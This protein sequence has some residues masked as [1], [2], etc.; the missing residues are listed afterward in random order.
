[1]LNMIEKFN[2]SWIWFLASLSCAIIFLIGYFF[3]FNMKSSDLAFQNNTS[4][5]FNEP[6]IELKALPVPAVKFFLVNED[7]ICES[8]KYPIKG[9]FSTDQGYF[10]TKAHKNYDKIKPDICFATEE[11]AKDSAGFIKK[12]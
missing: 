8:E 7:R 12:F 11:F 9:T 2:S 5:E 1:M 3:G 10:Y 6:T 4:Q